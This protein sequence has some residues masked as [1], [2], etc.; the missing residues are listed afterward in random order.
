[1]SHNRKTPKG[2]LEK[3]VIL[4]IQIRAQ[5]MGGFWQGILDSFPAPTNRTH[6]HRMAFIGSSL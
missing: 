1:M 2:G 5:I 6:C 3:G 4:G